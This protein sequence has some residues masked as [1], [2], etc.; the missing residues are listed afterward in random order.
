MKM[1]I[2]AL[3]ALL[4]IVFNSYG[5]D[6]TSS[7]SPSAALPYGHVVNLM[8]AEKVVAKILSGVRGGERIS[9]AVV[10]NNGRLVL[11]KRMDD[12]SYGTVKAAIAKAETS[13][14]FRQ[15]SANFADQVNSGAAMLT[16]VPDLF[17]APGGTPLIVDGKIIGAVGVS[18]AT[19]ERDDE[20]ARAGAKSLQ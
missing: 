9:V 17:P 8:Q 12:S 1:N 2:V 13:A 3:F 4:A 20:L 6:K 11:F 7:G 10:E 16:T 14:L 18:G 5:E 15:N 19:G